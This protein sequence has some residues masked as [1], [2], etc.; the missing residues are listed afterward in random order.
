MLTSSGTSWPC[1]CQSSID[2]ST[3]IWRA[4]ALMWIGALVEPP[5][6]ELTTMQFSNAWRVQG[7]SRAHGVA[8]A[9]RRRRGGHDLDELL[10]VD[11]AGGKPLAC[12]PHHGAGA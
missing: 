12:L 10:V 7:G 4:S 3:P 6:A 9:D 5:I 11:L 1:F 2:S 8:M